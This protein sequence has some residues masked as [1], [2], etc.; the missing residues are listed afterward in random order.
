MSTLSWCKLPEF[1]VYLGASFGPI[2][3]RIVGGLHY[4]GVNVVTTCWRNFVL[5][6]LQKFTLFRFYQNTLTFSLL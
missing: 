3:V 6:Q 5:T 2:Q 4:C 1:L